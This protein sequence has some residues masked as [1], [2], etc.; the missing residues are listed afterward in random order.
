M[1]ENNQPLMTLSS[2]SLGQKAII[3]GF[4]FDTTEGERIQEMGFNPGEQLEVVRITPQ[5]DP[6]EIKIRGYF[7]SLRKQQAEQ[8]M[9]KL[10]S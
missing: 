2:L 6:I 1:Q 9:V 3:V 4:S 10:F 8:I 7:L 5:G